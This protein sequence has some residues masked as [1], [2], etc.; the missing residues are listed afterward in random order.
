MSI[1]KLDEKEKLYVFD[2]LHDFWKERKLTNNDEEDNDEKKIKITKF[3]IMTLFLLQLIW[4]YLW[5]KTLP[6][7]NLKTVNVN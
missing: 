1:V 3:S 5:V 4:N 2:T 6:L 7:K